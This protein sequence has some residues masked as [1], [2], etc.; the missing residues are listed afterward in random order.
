MT[1]WEKRSE[2]FYRTN[3][4]PNQKYFLCSLKLHYSSSLGLLFSNFWRYGMQE[5]RSGLEN[6]D[7]LVLTSP[8]ALQ[9]NWSAEKHK[10]QG[11][12]SACLLKALCL[13]SYLIQNKIFQKEARGELYI[14][15]QKLWSPVSVAQPPTHEDLLFAPRQTHTHMYAH[16][17]C[18]VSSCRNFDFLWSL[19][20]SWSYIVESHLHDATEL[21][22]DDQTVVL[23]F[24]FRK[25]S[26]IPSHDW[27]ITNQWRKNKKALK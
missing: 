23:V 4:P 25:Q 14:K 8:L 26:L 9:S 15:Q 27:W 6:V 11:V 17:L 2:L 13:W 19:M 12:S 18:K 5:V 10:F 24:S 21:L 1:D 22:I 7:F 20:L 3:I 16:L